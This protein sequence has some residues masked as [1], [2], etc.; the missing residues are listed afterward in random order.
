MGRAGR[1]V[2]RLRPFALA[3]ALLVL[4]AGCGDATP[5]SE[6]GKPRRVLDSTAQVEDTLQVSGTADQR[7]LGFLHARYG[8][9]ARLDAPWQD[10]WD[11]TEVEAQRPVTRSVCA[12]DTRDTD[13]HVQT[14]LAVCQTLDDAASVE[15]GRLD[16][17][18]LRDGPAVGTSET[19]LLVIAQ[20]LQG[21]Y[22]RRGAPGTVQ[23]EPLGPQRHAFRITHGEIQRG[24]TL[25]SRSY[26]AV[27]ASRL[28]EVALLREH[29]DN[30]AARPCGDAG[31]GCDDT[32]FNVDF[33]IAVG[34]ADAVDG[35][36][37]LTVRSRGQDCAGPAHSY[38]LVAFD[39]VARRYAVPPE[40]QRADCAE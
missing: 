26:V 40:L 22:G 3:S 38:D 32:P 25:A 17:Y 7:L 2:H 28:R 21:Q 35:Y 31:K 18:V 15:P 6:P 14:L 24:V 12:R 9:N 19:P 5:A 23:V 13:G 20:R 11:D 39:P 34:T 1:A 36:W 29:I 8:D 4:L 33:S 37:P 10:Q 16:L 27:H 30:S